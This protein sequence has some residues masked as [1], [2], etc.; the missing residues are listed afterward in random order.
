M[1]TIVLSVLLL[2][3]CSLSATAQDDAPEV[4]DSSW[5]W[6]VAPYVWVP[7]VEGVLK[8]ENIETGISTDF[9]SPANSVGMSFNFQGYRLNWGLLLDLTY[10]DY[11]VDNTSQSVS[12]YKG[13][14]FTTEF[15]LIRLLGGESVHWRGLLGGR[16]TYLDRSVNTTDG[17]VNESRGGWID[18]FIG[19]GLTMPL[20]ERHHIRARGDIGGFGIGSKLAWQ[21]MAYY[22]YWISRKVTIL[23]G[24]R[25][26]D[27]DYD[28]GEG[29]DQLIYDI[30]THGPALALSIAL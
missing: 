9:F 7:Q 27:I 22:Q 5:Q 20:A 12:S 26:L 11:T 10:L 18:P 3:V 21:L 13:Q 19:V 17:G 2:L 25:Y 29:R 15:A 8:V 24:Y 4:V 28:K 14:S 16:W 23:A 1:K 6:Y 30:R